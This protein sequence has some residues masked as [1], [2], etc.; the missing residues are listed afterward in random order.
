MLWKGKLVPKGKPAVELSEE[1]KSK[2]LEQLEEWFVNSQSVEPP[3]IDHMMAVLS[4]LAASGKLRAAENWAEMLQDTLAERMDKDLTLKLLQ[5]RGE[6]RDN[7]PEFRDVCLKALSKVFKGQIGQGIVNS[8]GFGGIVEPKEC[9]RR[10]ALLTS[11]KPGVLCHD[12]TWGFGVV[13]G[14]EEFYKKVI[15]DFDKK[16]GHQM[17]FAYAGE[18]LEVLSD[19]HLFA[20]K[21]RDPDGFAKLLKEDPAEIVR[22]AI[23]SFGP[24]SSI[25]IREIFTGPIVSDAEWKGFWETARKK[26]KQDPFISFPS[27]REQPIRIMEHATDQRN[28]LLESLRQERDVETILKL[29][30]KLEASYGSEDSKDEG[31][32]IAAERLAFA[33]KGVRGRGHGTA[34]IIIMTAKRIGISPDLID[35]SGMTEE[36]FSPDKFLTAAVGMPAKDVGK[37][38]AHLADSDS[39]RTAQLML[40]L[41]P[42]MQMNVLNDAMEFLVCVGKQNECADYF[43]SVVRSEQA[44]LE[45]LSWLCRHPDE[46]ESWSVGNLS[47]ILIRSAN[48][49]EVSRSGKALQ[50]Q[51]QLRALFE[52]R[53]WMEKVLGR[54]DGRQRQNLMSKINVSKGW[55]AVEQRSVMAIMIKL[56]PE[57]GKV[58]ASD[59]E[60]KGPQG[61]LGRFTS[62]RSYNQRV[63]QLRRLVT[64]EIPKNSQEIGIAR[65]YGDLR[66][67]SEYKAAKEHQN[68]LMRR[69]EE[70]ENG[71]RE[72][73]GT[74]FKGF[75]E[76]AAGVGTCV[77]VKD[78]QGIIERY[79]ILGEWDGD[80]ELAIISSTSVIAGALIGRKVGDEVVLQTVSGEKKAGIVEVTG[81]S[82]AV[83]KWISSS[84]ID[85]AD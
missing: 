53:Q 77:V 10:L 62:W 43:R 29:V 28:E 47:E 18:V 9:L 52:Q 66:E 74:D 27:N 32:V 85:L 84:A 39:P 1:L 48:A 31:K 2:S 69:Q 36:L 51:K 83:K 30:D 16:H 17:S 41:L 57:L 25:R 33:L 54:M 8:A 35:I 81:L 7:V 42:R 67:N 40:S 20:M 22:I 61:K 13:S 71:L 12:K 21:H 80:E 11:L 4:S 70:W 15:V 14:V 68:I 55:E 60:E 65:S 59:A 26:L 49:L 72:V 38:I 19:R 82:D 3:P 46:A 6:W 5:L 78:D 24:L 37:L 44:S 56:Y 34:A 45:I 64:D 63:E 58:L 75:A 73:K 23:R 79:N 76:D 50:T